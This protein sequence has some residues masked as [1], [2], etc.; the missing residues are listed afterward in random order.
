MDNEP[1]STA[2]E[3]SASVQDQVAGHANARLSLE[4][5]E[6]YAAAN[7]HV[8]P[9]AQQPSTSR[10]AHIDSKDDVLKVLGRCLVLPV[11]P[12]GKYRTPVVTLHT[13][14]TANL[15]SSLI[16]RQ[17]RQEYLLGA[18]KWWKVSFEVPAAV[19]CDAAEHMH[20]CCFAR[21]IC[22]HIGGRVGVGELRN[23]CSSSE[24]NSGLDCTQQS[25][26]RAPSAARVHSCK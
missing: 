7:G 14:D 20:E 21:C 26:Q 23:P 4:A 24:R 13:S 17:L 11:G 16:E 1:S 25:H 10:R 15:Y 9:F 5:E 6:G 12:D 19:A 3:N 2:A 8:D 18:E 22:L